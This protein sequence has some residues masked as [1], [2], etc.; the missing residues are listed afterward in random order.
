M[1]LNNFFFIIFFA[2][3]FSIYWILAKTIKLQCAR[4]RVLSIYLLLCSYY[5]VGISDIRFL[6]CVIGITG[7]SYGTPI[8]YEKGVFGKKQI[9]IFLG[10]I[11]NLL[12][13]GVF[14]Y[15]D[16]FCVQITRLLGSKSVALEIMLP[17]GISFYTF[18][19]IGYIVD[20]YHKKL[21][22]GSSFLDVAL[23][24]AFFPKL[25]SGPI[26]RAKDFFAQLPSLGE[27]LLENFKCGIQIFAIGCFKKMVLAD[28]LGVFVDEVFFAPDAFHSVTILWA[29]ISYSL[30]IYFDF[31]GYSDM[32]IGISKMFGFDFSWNFN[33]PYLSKNL[34]EF[35]KRWHISL[36]SWLQEYLYYS[37]GGNRKG[38]MHTYVNLVLTMLLGGL[39]HGASWTFVVW[40]LLHGVGLVVHKLFMKWKVRANKSAFFDTKLWN[41]FSVVLTFAYVTFCWIWFRASSFENAWNMIRRMFIYHDGILQPYTWTIYAMVVLLIATI[42]MWKRRKCDGKM[43]LRLEERY[44]LLN[45]NTICGLCLFFVFCG[46]IIGLAYFGNTAFIYGAF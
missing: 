18:S 16:F 11:V 20:A 36:S 43:P 15:L 14:K 27:N 21:E 1:S 34:T 10:V 44:I 3:T 30:Q 2:V 42:V 41:G 12:F 33:F 39:W 29:V 24:I 4:S 26:V 37:L 23:Y 17:I 9:W 28:H 8:L 35:W 7:V 25:S 22:A 13:L 38:V 46:L 31:S 40:G 45:L 32:A 19:S 6:L 5:F